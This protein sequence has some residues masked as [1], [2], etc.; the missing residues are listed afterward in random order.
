MSGKVSKNYKN[1]ERQTRL[2]LLRKSDKCAICGV[3]FSSMRD[4]TLDHIIPKSKGGGN[5]LQNLQLAHERCN[6]EKGN[7]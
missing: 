3:K 7:L 6:M 2:F 4:I 5:D 1:K